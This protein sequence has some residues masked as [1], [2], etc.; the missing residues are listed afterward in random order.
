MPG[1]NYRQPELPRLREWT[2]A[3][4][5]ATTPDAGE[6]WWLPFGDPVLDRLMLIGLAENQDVRIA[7]ARIREARALVGGAEAE[8]LPSADGSISVSRQGRSYDGATTHNVFEA[9][10]L[11]TWEIDLFGG[12]RRRIQSATAQTAAAYARRDA[13]VLTL[14]AEIARAYVDFL[15]AEEALRI[16]R[17]TLGNQQE[18]VDITSVRYEAGLTNALD[19]TQAERQ[20]LATRSELPRFTAIQ[21]EALHRLERLLGTTPGGLDDLLP[22]PAPLPPVP[23]AD[24][25]LSSPDA[26]LVNRPDIRLAE[27]L[28]QAA[29]AD[30][31]VARADWLPRISLSALFGTRDV[32]PESF[33]LRSGRSWEVSG[34]LFQTIFDFGRIDARIQAA[35]ARA[36]AQVADLRRVV[37]LAYAEVETSLASYVQREQR[38]RDLAAALVK[39]RETLELARERYVA[40]LSGFLD[41][42]DAQ[43]VVF[44]VELEQAVGR[45]DVARSFISLETA[46]GGA[47]FADLPEPDADRLPVFIFSPLEEDPN[48]AYRDPVATQ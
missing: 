21:A 35:D 2:E 13:V 40:G 39:S 24:I 37:L 10:F 42:V 19:V 23:Q 38:L 27:N 6:A 48:S 5:N 9:M 1:P 18:N 8:L 26:V 15:D 41:V 28:L 7:L 45:A 30:Q 20:L 17:D 31:G 29:V 16:T 22:Q 43:R 33:F 46:L 3:P 12:T 44:Q 14:T 25:V 11:P 32:D 34:S 4:A 47:T 36:D